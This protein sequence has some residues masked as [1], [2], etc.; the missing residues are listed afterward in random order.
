MGTHNRLMGVLFILL[1]AIAADT[2]NAKK[3]ADRGDADAGR[4]L[5]VVACTGCHVVSV[6]QPFAPLIKGPPDFREIANRPDVT[7]AS[8]RRTIAALPLVPRKG[9]HGEPT[10][11]R[12][13]T[14]RRGGLHHDSLG[15]SGKSVVR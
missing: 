10:S 1:L 8:L 11:H 15:A 4:D 13:P 5:A 6:D 7:L 12:R 9:R 2:A 3:P 14:R